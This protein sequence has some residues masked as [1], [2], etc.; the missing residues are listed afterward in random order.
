LLS[1]RIVAGLGQNKADIIKE[2]FR[3]T[4]AE[5]P[6]RFAESCKYHFC[7][8]QS[9]ASELT[10]FKTPWLVDCI[11]TQK[12]KSKAIVWL[13]QRRI[14]QLK[15]NDRDYNNNGMSDLLA[16]EGSAYDLNINMFNVLQRTITDGEEN[17]I[18]MIPIDR[19]ERV[20]HK[21]VIFSPHPMMT[22][23]WEEVLFRN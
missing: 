11:W 5:V 3:K 22:L 21:K 19:N 7:L 1:K 17:P 12:L 20:Q 2:Q 9:A 15:A 8:D 14:K 6:L 13:C 4:S 16:Q 18:Q 23:R 10:R